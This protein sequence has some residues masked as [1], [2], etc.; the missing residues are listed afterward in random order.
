VGEDAKEGCKSSA[1]RTNL[2]PGAN[3]CD[4]ADAFPPNAAASFNNPRNSS[5]NDQHDAP[6]SVSHDVTMIATTQHR[7]TI[8][9]HRSDVR[10]ILVGEHV[11]EDCDNTETPRYARTHTNTFLMPSI[12]GMSDVHRRISSFCRLQ[13]MLAMTMN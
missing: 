12:V 3:R 11:E 6:S 8:A 13:N 7:G 9:T 1:R 10:R 2:M 4:A 5:C